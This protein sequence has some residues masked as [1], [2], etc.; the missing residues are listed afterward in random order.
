[1]TSSNYFLEHVW[2]IP[3][4]PLATAVFMV[5]LGR[6]LPKEGVNFFCVGSVVLSFVHVIGVAF[7]LFGADAGHRIY[8]QILFEWL[9][10]GA[11]PAVGGPV[12]F[13]IDWG[14][15]VDPLSCVMILV[16]AGVGLLIHI[17]ATGYMAR[18]RGYYRFFGY[19]NLS[20][21]FMLTL[22][23]A[24][25]LVLLFLGWVGVSI[26]GY[27]LS[28]VNFSKSSAAAGGQKIVLS[29]CIGDASLLLGIFYVASTFGTVRFT[30]HSLTDP[31]AFA[32]INETLGAMVSLSRLPAQSAFLGIS[33]LLCL[34]A[35]FKSAQVPLFAWLIDA[36]EAPLPGSAL[37][38]SGITI[39]AGAYLV[40]RLNAIIQFAPSAL[41]GVAIVGAF[42]GICAAL[43]SAVQTDILKILTYATICQIGIMFLALGEGAFSEGMF[44]M[45]SQT[46]ITALL[47][48]AA[49]GVIY[50]LSGERDIRKM[51]GL[52]NTVHTASRP[53]LIATLAIVGFPLFSGFFATNEILGYA[54]ARAHG[55]DA[56]L[57]LWVA[58]LISIG[59]T[60]VSMFRLLFLV[61][62]GFSRLP[63]ELEN[64]I[65]ESP[66]AMMVS[67]PILATFCIVLGW[68]DLPM[69]WGAQSPFT[70]FLN[71]VVS[72]IVPDKVT[73]TFAIQPVS[74]RWLLIVAF[75][76]VGLCGLWVAYAK[77]RKG[78]PFPSRLS[79]SWPKLH[80]LLEQRFHF[81][82]IVDAVL[83][84]RAKD[85][86]VACAL[87][88]GR[89]IDR[90]AVD[91]FGWLARS[92]SKFAIWWDRWVIDALVNFSAR[93]FRFVSHPIR[94]FQ[95]GVFSTYAVFIMIGISL[96]LAY[97]GHHMY[98]L[99]RS[100]R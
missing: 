83:V 38:Q 68:L 57:F 30:S 37:F 78:S 12:S 2:L 8:Q 81:D 49:G 62:F 32:G 48:L 74:T 19:M 65:H 47:F 24:N 20:L 60:A 91:G 23:L 61:F 21:F 54:F 79:V 82:Q 56:H 90:F 39:G 59:I 44:Q 55:V 17:F 52:W 46:F 80:S 67:L 13:V 85:L 11:I 14:Y 36:L 29:N 31:V 73:N 41:E 69:L 28:T 25:N 53:F 96:L 26:C 18:E 27:L 70:E 71:P 64:R 97:Y 33:F 88:D 45:M 22:V 10:P 92:L 3:F 99:V 35:I 86:S 84:D 66:K 34:A 100:L 43:L 4:F 75:F 6:F 15:L 72:R 94:L 1:V 42:A 5:L 89:V 40:V 51:G 87:L 16:V 76:L 98:S 77:Y 7:A 58:G 95:S 93:F 9:T 50:A 63:P